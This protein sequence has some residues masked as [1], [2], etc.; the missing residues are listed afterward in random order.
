[1]FAQQWS[2]SALDGH[3]EWI[4]F[5]LNEYYDP[6]YEYQLEQRGGR[7][8]FQG[9]RDAVREWASNHSCEVSG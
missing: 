5:L 4:S 3:R 7:Y 1:G 9:D 2:Q 6:M 8:L